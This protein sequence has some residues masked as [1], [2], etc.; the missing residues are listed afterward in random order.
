MRYRMAIFDFDGTLA[1]SFP[2]VISV[3]N[4]VADR[5]KFRRV[6][7]EELDDLRLCD[8]REIMRRLGV[9]RWKL[10]MIARYVRTRMAEDIDQIGLFP[11]ARDMLAQLAGEGVKLAVVS[12]NGQG[13]I[14]TVLGPSSAALI[15]GFACGVSLFGKRN[16]LIKM[17]KLAEIDRA[18]CIVIGDELRDLDA[19]RAAGMAFGAATWG[20]TRREALAARGADFLFARVDQIAPTVL[21]GAP[22]P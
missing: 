4:D 18:D 12:A 6:V 16:K 21:H 14:E 22:P 3:M 2:W 5:F 19:A 11:G 20:A 13:T 1:D 9:K 7:A 17:A 15:G 8:A 10:P